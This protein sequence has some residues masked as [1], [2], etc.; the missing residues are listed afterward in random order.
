M[1]LVGLVMAGVVEPASGRGLRWGFL[2]VLFYGTAYA[3]I[4]LRY[5]QHWYYYLIIPA[6]LLLAV[7]GVSHIGRLLAGRLSPTG[8]RWAWLAA[9]A[10]AVI[11]L[12]PLGGAILLGMWSLWGSASGLVELG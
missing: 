8:R 1:L 10:V 4:G 7:N 5:S 2:W 3:L 11:G 6:L 12:V 9:R